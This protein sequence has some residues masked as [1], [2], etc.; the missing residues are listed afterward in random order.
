MHT[1][2]HTHTDLLSPFIHRSFLFT[3][4]TFTLTSFLSTPLSPRP[5]FLP[6]L[7]NRK[8]L[9]LCTEEGGGEGRRY[10]MEEMR[11]RTERVREAGGER[12][13]G[14]LFFLWQTKNSQRAEQLRIT[15]EDE[16]KH[17][18]GVKTT[19]RRCYRCLTSELGQINP[20]MSVRSNHKHVGCFLSE[21]QWTECEHHPLLDT[22]IQ[23]MTD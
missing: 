4:S 20:L 21:T 7:G 17:S 19:W 6:G 12:V 2:S 15:E 8:Q 18:W 13:G 3:V 11:E 5:H 16:R 14:F 9:F 10:W 22:V 1:Q 23:I